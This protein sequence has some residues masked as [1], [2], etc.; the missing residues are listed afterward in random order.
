MSWAIS[1]R[2]S[3]SRECFWADSLAQCWILDLYSGEYLITFG[4]L[5][6]WPRILL[7]HPVTEKDLLRCKSGTPTV[8]QLSIPLPAEFMGILLEHLPWTAMRKHTF[9]TES[10]PDSQPSWGAYRSRMC[11]FRLL[12]TWCKWGIQPFMYN[13]PLQ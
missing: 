4:L 6:G 5:Q 11:T 13:R 9:M 12:P 8:F 2:S 10:E 7:S 3:Y 1:P